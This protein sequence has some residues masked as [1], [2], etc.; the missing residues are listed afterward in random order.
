MSFSFGQ[1]FIKL[2]GCIVY[3]KFHH[4]PLSFFYVHVCI[5][6]FDSLSWMK[7]VSCKIPFFFLLISHSILIK[8][9]WN[10]M[11]ILFIKSLIM[12]PCFFY[13]SVFQFDA[14]VM[15]KGGLCKFSFLTNISF[16][17]CQNLME[18]HGYNVYL[19]FHHVQLF[20]IYAKLYYWKRVLN[21]FYLGFF[22][23]SK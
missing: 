2:H 12:C 14:L 15:E 1:N 5:F 16:R 20:F 13:L 17:F 6:Q 8:I 7:R 22:F 11:V 19:K 9:S 21:V 23:L 18:L 4:M 3:L 10:F